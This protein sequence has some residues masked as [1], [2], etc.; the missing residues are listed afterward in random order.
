[1]LARLFLCFF[2]LFLTA[3]AFADEAIPPMTVEG[4][5]VIT[6]NEAKAYFDSGKTLF[7]DV[8]NPINYGRGHITSAIAAPFENSEADERQRRAFLM[9]LPRDKRAP[10]IVYSH[11]KTGWK[12]YYAASEAIK[13]GYGNIMWLREGFKAWE[14]NNFSVSSGPE[15]N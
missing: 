12:S 1:M 5:R 7:V 9:K 14:S 11:G 13:A 15:N 4:G 6:V 10:V 2:A 8:R 3:P